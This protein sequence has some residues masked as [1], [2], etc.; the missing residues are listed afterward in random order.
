MTKERKLQKS[1]FYFSSLK[2][3]INFSFGKTNK[4]YVL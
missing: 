2:M 4:F 3:Q 1:G